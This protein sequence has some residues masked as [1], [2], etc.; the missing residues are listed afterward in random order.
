M[1]DQ[2]PVAGP[3][4]AVR[5]VKQAEAPASFAGLDLV[6]LCTPAEVSLTLAPLALEAGLPRRR[7]LGRVPARG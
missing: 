5:V 2:L 1:G 7:R 3:A 6:F 4:A